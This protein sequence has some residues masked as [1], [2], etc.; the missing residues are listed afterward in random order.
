M[1]LTLDN[2]FDID[3]DAVERVAW[4]GETVELSS[5]A[6]ARMATARRNFMNLIERPDAVVYGVTT[7]YGQNAR[8]R[9]SSAERLQ[10]ASRPPNAAAA[11]WGEP[12]PDRIVRAMILARLANF[13]DGYSAVSPGVAQAVVAMLSAKSL[14]TVPSRGH[15]GAGDGLALDLRGAV[16]LRLGDPLRRHCQRP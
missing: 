11:S 9:L 2:R 4:R 5:K 8:N 16:R 6:I 15:G 13:L 12:F 14:P 10:H 3:L 1:T 7:G